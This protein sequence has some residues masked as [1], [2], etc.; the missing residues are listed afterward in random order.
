MSSPA[1]LI[2]GRSYLCI[3]TCGHLCVSIDDQ[4]IWW[5]DR[6]GAC[7]GFPLH[8]CLVCRARHKEAT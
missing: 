2:A 5:H 6:C 8:C 4:T 1:A 3:R 7:N